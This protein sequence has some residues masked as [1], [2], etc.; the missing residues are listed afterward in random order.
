[1]PSDLE[2]DVTEIKI[3]VAR[4]EER[5]KVFDTNEHDKRIRSLEEY[6]AKLI[7]LCAGIGFVTGILSSLIIKLL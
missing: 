3:T 6:K 5:L 7:G 2:K 4:I 1:M